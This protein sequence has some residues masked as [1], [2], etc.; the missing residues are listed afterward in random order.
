M[1]GSNSLRV[2]ILV[3]LSLMASASNGI[4]GKKK[5][6]FFPLSFLSSLLILFYKFEHF[7]FQFSHFRRKNSVERDFCSARRNSNKI[8]R[9]LQSRTGWI[10][11]WILASKCSTILAECARWSTKTNETEKSQE[12]HHFPWRWYVILFLILRFRRGGIY[13]T[14][15]E[16]FI[17]FLFKFTHLG[18]SLS[19]VAATR[20]YLGG[21]EKQLSF[22]KFAHFGL[23]KVWKC[24]DYILILMENWQTVGKCR[25]TRKKHTE[26]V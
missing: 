18:M 25:A 10:G 16:Y 11:C 24:I 9:H 21:E 15:L 23:S 22:E 3:V 4:N 8:G 7:F 1:V 13:S 2:L 20:M 26:F 17:Y 6:C 5:K 12:C 14:H 19:T